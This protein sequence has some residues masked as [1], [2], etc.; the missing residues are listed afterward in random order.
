MR[1]RPDAFSSKGVVSS[2]SLQSSMVGARI[3]EKGGNVADA[4]IA[5]SAVL[6]VTQNNLCGLGGDMFALIRMNGKPIVDLNGSGRASGN[7]S[8]DYFAGKGIEKL[9]PRGEM[10]AL[11]VPGI[12]DA[13]RTIHKDY[14]TM[15][16][17]ELLSP[18][19]KLAMEGFPVTHNYHRSVEITARHLGEYGWADVFTPGG[20]IPD[21][22]SLFKQKDLGT[23]LSAIAEEGPETYYSGNLVDKILKGLDE[24]GTL[25][26]GEDFRKHSTTL[27]K[28]LRTNYRGYDVYETNPNSQG[29][30]AILWLNLYQLMEPDGTGNAEGRFDSVIRSGLLAYGERNKHI[31]DPQ[32]HN[33]PDGFC[34]SKY[35]ENI[36]SSAP[37]FIQTK[38]ERKD[39]GD[40]TYFNLADGDGNSLSVIQSNYMGF[41]SGIVPR[42]TGF[43]LQNRGSYFS[44]DPEHHNALMPNKRTFHTLCAAMAEKDGEFQF[45]AGTM[46]GDIQP[47]IH[48]QMITGIIDEGLD[49]QYIL[50]RPRWAFPH[51][52]YEKPGD[53]VVESSLYE[54]VNGYGRNL[55]NLKK[56]DDLSSQT[57]HA[58]IVQ[59]N[60]QG[61]IVGG[62][63]PRGDGISISVL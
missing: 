19:I 33:L 59:R 37:D 10:A 23:T 2:S 1:T 48:F 26:D 60:G 22:G 25:F 43:V 6:C 28:P 57:G 52:I 54:T 41:G 7:A 39:P 12:V 9:P 63:D 20:R 47:Q 62:S 5:T 24:T 44:L 35:A 50:D 38:G 16:F 53:M 40:T 15:E 11:T 51:T 56:I 8:I 45:S 17:K 27:T 42:N 14:A 61:V 36:L 13:W 3:L 49:P 34:S 55:L 21:I 58:Q 4:A 31:T 30:T 29:A 18:A 46:G 32:Y